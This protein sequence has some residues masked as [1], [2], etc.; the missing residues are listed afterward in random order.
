MSWAPRLF[1]WH[2]W[3]GYVVGLQVLA[4]L[5]GG[6]LFAWVPFQAW[7]KGGEVLRK[8]EQ[9][10]PADWAARI[11]P[12]PSGLGDLLA[13]QSVATAAGP[14][15]KLRY[16]SGEQWLSMQG[17]PLPAPDAETVTA[18]ARQLY[19]GD[20]GVQD[21]QRV[22]EVPRRLGLVR[23]LGERRDVWRVRFDD[24]LGTRFYLDGRSGEL[25]AV[26]NEAWVLYDFFWRL[27]LM[28][29]EGGEDFNNPLLR[30]ASL[31]GIG[32]V[33]TGLALSILALRRR[34]RRRAH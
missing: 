29:Y 4:W 8:P 1:R 6:L 33:L 16:A 18:Y 7:V 3:V 9:A 22:T 11:G 14:A 10:L 25:L 21:V 34:W 15:L 12:M 19:R 26:R 31:L 30:G 23:E 32:L 24:R 13:V 20:A 17:G 2:R 27:H 5:L 28:D